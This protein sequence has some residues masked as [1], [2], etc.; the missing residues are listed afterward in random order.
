MYTKTSSIAYK[1]YGSVL[2]DISMFPYSRVE[3][4]TIHRHNKTINQLFTY[5]S[6]VYIRVAKGMVLLLVNDQPTSDGIQQFVIHRVTRVKKGVYMNFVAISDQIKL[7]IYTTPNA[8]KKFYH[9]ED[10]I[11]HEKTVE[12]FHIQEIY[13]YYYQIRHSDYLFTG[14]EHSYWELT[15]IDNGRM[16]TEVDGVAHEL[17]SFDLMLYAPHQFHNQQAFEGTPC[18]YITI[19]FDMDLKDPAPFFNKVFHLDKEAHRILNNFMKLAASEHTSYT[20]D[21]LLCYL[22]ELLITLLQP[23]KNEVPLTEIPIQQ[24]S[25]NDLLNDIIKHIN[26]NIFKPLAIEE[27]CDTFLISRS[28]LQTLFREQLNMA[29]KQY[30]N[31]LKLSKSKFMIKEGKY[32]ISEITVALGFGSIHY[33]SR[34][35]K[36]RY[37]ITP[38]DYAKSIF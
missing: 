13:T 12:S 16:V 22:K 2:Q 38:T 36:Q 14:E 8:Q 4:H 26:E 31:E 1:P 17:N 29:P 21:F 24:Q 28:S 19:M 6:D 7:D 11:E 34:K 30:I 23:T 3:K 5:S 33:F 9:I 15:Y 37:G 27:I 10:N 32:T 20:K 25:D 35:F 18:S